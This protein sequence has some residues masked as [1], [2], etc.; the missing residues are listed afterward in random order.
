MLTVMRFQ[1]FAALV[2][3]LWISSSVCAQEESIVIFQNASVQY[4][5]AAPETESRDGYDSR[6]HGQTIEARVKLPDRPHNLRDQRQIILLLEVTPDIIE[7]EQGARLGD[8]WTRLGHVALVLP[9]ESVQPDH[10]DSVELM[11]FATGFGGQTHYEEDITAFAPHLAGDATIRTSITTF[12]KPA[13]KVSLRIEYRPGRA[14]YRRPA[15]AH[16]AF[17]LARLTA[18]VPH[19]GRQVTIPPDLSQPRIRIL[20]TGH[21][22]QQ[23]F[24]A[25]THVLRIDGVEI[26]RWRPWREDAGD[27]HD[28][29]PTSYRED[30][31]GRVLWSSDIDRAGWIPGAKVEPVTIPAPELAPGVHNLEL[32]IEGI[33]PPGDLDEPSGYWVCSLVILADEPWPRKE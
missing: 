11:R 2:G 10:S 25:A 31:D 13:W 14:G 8:P 32:S 20:S 7:A 12:L 29:N 16:A 22:A 23:E 24:L 3:S 1:V 17:A 21:G 19:I 28:V 30:I 27:L 6:D 26:A 33:Q 15:L 5:P 18:E 9:A 4:D